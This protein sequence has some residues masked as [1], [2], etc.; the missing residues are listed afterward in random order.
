MRGLGKSGS[1]GGNVTG[2][3]SAPQ[4]QN[5]LPHKRLWLLVVLGVHDLAAKGLLVRIRATKPLVPVMT[6]AH[7]D[8]PIDF[9]GAIS[10][11]DLVSLVA[12]RGDLLHLGVELDM[13]AELEVVSVRV[14]VLQD[15]VLA[16]EVRVT[17]RHRKVLVL[18]SLPAGDDVHRLIHAMKPVTPEGAVSLVAIIRDPPAGQPPTHSQATE[19]GAHNTDS[20]HIGLLPMI[21]L[22][23]LQVSGVSR[24]VLEAAVEGQHQHQGQHREPQ[25]RVISQKTTEE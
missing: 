16:W 24:G 8:A 1:L 12:G 10:K 15:L 3:V 6:I 19:S 14:E 5:P 21:L 20:G 23:I 4:D 7:D 9:L 17:L 13:L 18:S 22:V 25:A 2:R 11:G